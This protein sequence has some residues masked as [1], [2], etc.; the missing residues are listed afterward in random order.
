MEIESK[1]KELFESANKSKVTKAPQDVGVTDLKK[2]EFQMNTY[3]KNKHGQK[4]EKVSAFSFDN[5]TS[6]NETTFG[7][8][9]DQEIEAKYSNKKWTGLPQYMK[10]KLVQEYF[11]EKEIN[12]EESLMQIKSAISKK[13]DD[14][15]V[16][17][18]INGKISD[19]IM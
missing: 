4:A 18:H 2:L 12:N 17:D 6:Y 19:I 1:V 9:V 11:I 7:Q 14:M 10:W 8:L 5:K 15:V 16:Y 13:K 3:L